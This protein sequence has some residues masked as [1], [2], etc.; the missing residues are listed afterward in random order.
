MNHYSVTITTKNGVSINLTLLGASEEAVQE[1]I[2]KD[3]PDVT[4]E[5][6]SLLN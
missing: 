5:D 3:Y 1:S 6:I 2:Q 4:I